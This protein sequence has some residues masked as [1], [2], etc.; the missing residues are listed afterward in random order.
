MPN[1]P[2]SEY[3]EIHD[4]LRLSD[5]Y[6]EA[7]PEYFNYLKL[8]LHNSRP[9]GTADFA[10]LQSLAYFGICDSERG[11]KN[12]DAA[13]ANCEKAL[14]YDALDPYTHYALAL[15]YLKKAS[16]S[17]ILAGLDPAIEHFQQVIDLNPDL[18]EAGMARQNLANIQKL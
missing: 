17:N 12:Y 11:L 1:L 13:I 2:A 18:E 6:V 16:E 8:S 14:S 4:G 15:S 7:L 3:I 9:T 5:K 10:D